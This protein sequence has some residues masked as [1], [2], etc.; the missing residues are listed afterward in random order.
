[1]STAPATA[2]GRG[3]PW[4]LPA[5]L[6]L[7]PAAVPAQDAQIEALE[8]QLK[9]R[10]KVILELLERVDALERRVGTPPRPREPARTAAEGEKPRHRPGREPATAPGAVV[11]EEDAAERALERSLAREGALLLPPGVLEL[12]PAFTYVRREDSAPVLRAAAGGL[13]AG[14]MERNADG[15]TAGLSLR[16]GLPWESQ[17]ELGQDYRWRQVDRVT[18]VGFAPQAASSR[19]GSGAGDLRIGLAKSLAREGLW[20][21]DLVGRL[22]WD[23]A[24]GEQSDDGVPLGGGFHQLR[25]SLSAIKRQDPVAF[26]GGLAYEHA[27]EEDRVRPGATLSAS[28]GGFVALSPETSLRLQLSAAHQD[29]TELSGRAVDGS[30]RTLG[31]FTVGGS[32][33]LA[34]GTLLNLSAGIGLTDDADDFSISLSLPIRLDGRLF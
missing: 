1:M 20:R 17:L 23:T 4:W 10:D 34:P 33:L 19:E 14:T 2:R 21:P 7:L 11:V 18:R 26:V 6:L 3:R 28:V 13:T 15:L 27:F 9:E 12:E 29:E 32:T 16:L 30:D 31:T 5:L 8:R 24:S 25:A 22:T